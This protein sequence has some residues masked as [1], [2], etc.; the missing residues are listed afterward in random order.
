MIQLIQVAEPTSLTV[1]Q[2]RYNVFF[3]K[4]FLTLRTTFGLLGT[5]R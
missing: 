4:F 5:V 2:Q 1:Q 3:L